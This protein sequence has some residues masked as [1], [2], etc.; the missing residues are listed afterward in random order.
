MTF[1]EW[2]DSVF[3]GKTQAVVDGDYDEDTVADAYE[4]GWNACRDKWGGMDYEDT[5]RYETP[6]DREDVPF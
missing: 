5:L 6:K 1:E 2:A 3:L 4:A